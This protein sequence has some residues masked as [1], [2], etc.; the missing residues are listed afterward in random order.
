MRNLTELSLNNRPLVWYF[1]VVA[2][3]GGIL[4]YFE[5]GRMEDPQF[6]VRDMLVAAYWPGA[7][8]E[9]M[10]AQVTDKIE[11]KLQDI[12]GLDHVR[13]ETRPGATVIYVELKDTVDT[14]TIRALWRDVRNYCKDI[15][16]LPDG[17]LGPY[18]NDTYD[19]VFG[20]IYALT[21]DG[22]SY[23]ELRKNAEDIRRLLLN[24]NDV[25]KI[26]LIGVQ[27]EVVYVEIEQMKLSELGISPQTISNTLA[28]QNAMIPAGMVDTSSDNVYLRVTGVF[29]NVEEIRN[30]PI[31][32]G[33]KIFKL[34]DIA[35]VERRFVD[36]PELKMF[37]NGK[38]AIGIAVAMENG[39]NILKLGE[40]LRNMTA[41]IQADLPLGLELNQVSNQPQVVEES[42]GEFVETLI[43]AIVIVLGVSFMS[44]GG[45]SW[46]AVYR[47][48]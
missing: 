48:S 8:A 5:L 41:S 10:Q 33:G 9:E 23:E 45:L 16:D 47:L 31:N 17:V 26:N 14:S 42:I 25:K 6:V 29:D 28:A 30:L 24:I 3:V 27:K 43:L 18:Y 39:G 20:S 2:F 19:E 1:I 11:K 21:G 7:T 36:P 46:R 4:A 44:L 38:P 35:K 32:A 13:S 22:F 15:T 12:P 40:N 34:S 37:F